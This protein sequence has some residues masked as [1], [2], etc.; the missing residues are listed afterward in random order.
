ME[1]NHKVSKLCDICRESA[2]N[3]CFK[4]IMYLCDSCFKYIHEKKINKNH[5]KEKVDYFS[6]IYLKCP[7]HPKDRINLF[8]LDE[9]GKIN[10]YF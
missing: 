3:M 10:I 5:K 4:C 7:V 2:N 8:C 6:P 9:K 1:F